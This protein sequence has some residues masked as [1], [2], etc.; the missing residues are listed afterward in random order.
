MPY[1]ENEGVKIYYKVTGRGPSLVLQHG[2]AGTHLDWI[3]FVDYVDALKKKYQ[4]IL[5]DSRGRGKSDK[6]YVPEMHSMK[7]LVGDITAIL[8]DIGL[9]KAH[10]W[11]YS[12]G[13]RVGLAAGVY[14][15]E[16]FTS[17]IIGGAGLLEK[18]A[19]EASEGFN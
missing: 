17:L 8:D 3:K 18:D 19:P 9:E 4:L 2:L 7:N 14:A 6:P 16:R 11:G 13:G 15:S 12:F 5:L 1:A 10:F